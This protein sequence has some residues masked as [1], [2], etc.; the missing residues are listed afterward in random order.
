MSA[1]RVQ[2]KKVNV[3]EDG[4]ECTPDGIYKGVASCFGFMLSLLVVTALG[5]AAGGIFWT[6]QSMYA[7]TSGKKEIIVSMRK[8]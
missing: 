3:I 5:I 6:A 1:S 2:E 7:L 4:I 8:L